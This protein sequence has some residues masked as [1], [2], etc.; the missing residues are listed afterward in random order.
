ML[1]EIFIIS[2]FASLPK[3]HLLPVPGVSTKDLK[4]SEPRGVLEYESS[5]SSTLS[6]KSEAFIES[7]LS[8]YRF[9]NYGIS[10]FY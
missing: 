3:K 4:S 9:L 6:S 1:Y 2:C 7:R 8:A 5:L 10:V